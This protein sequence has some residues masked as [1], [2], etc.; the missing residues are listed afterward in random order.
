[1]TPATPSPATA[2]TD[3]PGTSR[4]ARAFALG[5]VGG[6]ALVGIGL[7]S[8]VAFAL[9]TGASIGG[10]TALDVITATLAWLWILGAPVATSLGWVAARKSGHRGAAIAAGVVFILWLMSTAWLMTVHR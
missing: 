3:A 1:M 8:V 2:R 5:L 9:T 4:T 10:G 7:A 6:A